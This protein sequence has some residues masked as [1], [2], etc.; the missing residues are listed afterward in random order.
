MDAL[1]GNEIMNFTSMDEVQNKGTIRVIPMKEIS[2]STSVPA[3]HQ[4]VLE[5]PSSLSSGN[6]DTDT[7]H[8]SLSRQGHLGPVSSM[9]L[10][11][12]MMPNSN[13]SRAMQRTEKRVHYLIQIQN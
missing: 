6:V 10:S 7:L 3:P 4:H 9:F 13:L 5:E 11:L 8:Q 2:P 1:F 12:A